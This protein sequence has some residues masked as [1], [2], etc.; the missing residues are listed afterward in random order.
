MTVTFKTI[1]WKCMRCKSEFNYRPKDDLCPM[2]KI[3]KIV[4]VKI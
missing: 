3:G 4:Q 2:C 1:Y